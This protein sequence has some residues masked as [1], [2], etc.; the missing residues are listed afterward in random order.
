MSHVDLDWPAAGVARLTIDNLARRNALDWAILDALAETVPGLDARCLI[1]R[2]AGTAFCSGYDLA[3]FD[4]EQPFEAQA[5][6]LVAHPR[7]AALDAIAAAPMPTIA[8]IEGFAIGGGL[9]LATVC[10]FRLASADSRFSMPPARLGIVYS[11]RGIGRLLELVGPARTREMLLLGASVEAATAARWGLVTEVAG[12]GALEAAALAMAERA[13]AL[14]A[15]AVAGNK[16]VLEQLLEA[17]RQLDGER[18]SKLL[19]LRRR[20]FSAPE[21]RAAA[22]S[23]GRSRKRG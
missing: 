15:A 1:L 18:E 4:P 20:S 22:A 14:P 13:A 16:Q 5:E 7:T 11:H 19:E 12:P 3:S 8:A 10:D 17:R 23:H 6:R 9:E 2:G 21:L